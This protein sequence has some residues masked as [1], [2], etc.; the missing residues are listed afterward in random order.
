MRGVAAKAGGVPAPEFLEKYLRQDFY[1][2]AMPNGQFNAS[3]AQQWFRNNTGPLGHPG[4]EKLR[5][6]A[7]RL[8]RYSPEWLL[9]I[10][11][12]AVK[13]IQLHPAFQVLGKRLSLEKVEKDATL[14][15]RIMLNRIEQRMRQLQAMCY[16]GQTCSVLWDRANRTIT[17]AEFDHRHHCPS[18]YGYKV[19]GCLNVTD[20]F[21]LTI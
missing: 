13:T 2:A 16:R 19:S 18:S 1:D 5:K 15:E 8:S 4:F 10:G 6:V 7:K 14:Q 17:R 20:S 9:R 12:K 21:G 3:R 11:V